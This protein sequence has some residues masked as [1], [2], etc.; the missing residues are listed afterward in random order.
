MFSRIDINYTG[1]YFANDFNGPLPNSEDET[2]N[3]V[4]DSFIKV[5]FSSVYSHMFKEFEIILRFK[6]ENLFD[7]RFNQSVVPNA[8]GSN[9]FEPSPGR[10]FYFTITANY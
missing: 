1:R 3:Y 9:F 5:N 6:V 8:F 2:D 10:S 4:N 7:E